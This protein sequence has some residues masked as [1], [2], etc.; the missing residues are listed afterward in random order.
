[1]KA[2]FYKIYQ[3]NGLKLRL[4]LVAILGILTFVSGSNI[5][6]ALATTLKPQSPSASAKN[7]YVHFSGNGT[8]RVG[9]DIRSGTYRTRVA[10]SGCYY[11]RLRGFSGTLNDIIANDFTN[12]PA[13]VTIAASDKGFQTIDCSTW[14]KDLSA[15]TKNKTTFR[16]GE[17]IVGTD[18]K[19]GTYRTRVA[20]SGC[21]Y[22]RLSGF[23]ATDNDIIANDFVSGSAIVTIAAS[24]KGFQ[25][26]DCGIWTN[27]L[28]AITKNKTT[29]SDG[30]YIVGTD[31][32]PGTYR[33]PGTSSGCYY[34]RLSG[35]SG[36]DND[37]IANDFVN[38]PAIVT[39]AG[40]DKGFQAANCGTWKKA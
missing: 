22:A 29:F 36:T 3:R 19:S 17:Y 9:K 40:K 5:S 4:F 6:V 8:F 10:S 27:N 33:T 39:I 21:Y 34:A 30:E 23:S 24:D 15:I 18:I 26:I 14:T 37:I 16:D 1:M 25:T 12:T 13:I 31:I 38:G 2:Y 28:S 35:F 20:S 7:T 32:K 11:A